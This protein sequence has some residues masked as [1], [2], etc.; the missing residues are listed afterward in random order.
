[1][2]IQIRAHEHVAV[3]QINGSVVSRRPTN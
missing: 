1:M 2:Q 3:V